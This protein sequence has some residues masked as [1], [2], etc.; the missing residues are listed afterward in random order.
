MNLSKLLQPVNQITDKNWLG[1]GIILIG[2]MQCLCIWDND[3]FSVYITP[4]L[5]LMMRVHM[6]ICT[7][8]KIMIG[9]IIMCYHFT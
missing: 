2:Q 1:K 4:L 3:C 8:T 5:F 9:L 6:C 7:Y